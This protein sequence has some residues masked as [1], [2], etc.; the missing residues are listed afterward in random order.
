MGW[1]HCQKGQFGLVG[2]RRR[3]SFIY[4]GVFILD[5]VKSLGLQ[6]RVF[7][8]MITLADPDEEHRITVPPDNLEE[9]RWPENRDS[10]Y[11][12]FVRK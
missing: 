4:L 12:D 10:R 3:G 8:A 6:N 1:R 7:L 5:T 2:K 9:L 11:C